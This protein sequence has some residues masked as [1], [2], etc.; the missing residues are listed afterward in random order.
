VSVHFV[1]VAE[2]SDPT[3]LELNNPQ[4]G[5]YPE[6]RGPYHDREGLLL[7]ISSDAKLSLA[8]S[9]CV[10]LPPIAVVDRIM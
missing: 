8:R 10:L 6:T 3:G 2:I 1:H 5:S 7:L 9:R 4:T